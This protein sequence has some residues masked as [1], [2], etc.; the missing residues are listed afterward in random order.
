MEKSLYLLE[1]VDGVNDRPFPSSEGQVEILSFTYN[2]SR[3]GG[4]PT[5]TATVMYGLC[6]DGKWTK[7]VYAEFRGERYF[8]K[9]TPTSHKSNEDAR[10][11]H[12]IELV[13]ERI[14]LDNVYFYDVVSADYA[15]DDKPVSNST[16]VVFFG[17]IYEFVSRL[18]QSMLASRVNYSVVVDEG[19]ESK[20]LDVERLMSFEDMFF[21]DVLQEIYKTY[22]LPYYFDGRT[23]HIG[24]SKSEEIP[25][26]EYGVSGALISIKKSN[27]NNKIINRITGR[28]SSDNIPFYYPNKTPK[29]D[30][31]LELSNPDMRILIADKLLFSEKIS[32]GVP[33][34]YSAN[35]F[36][37][38]LP[39]SGTHTMTNIFKA[40]GVEMPL[41]NTIHGHTYF[42][43]SYFKARHDGDVSLCVTL[44]SVEFNKSTFGGYSN[45]AILFVKEADGRGTIAR[46]DM[47]GGELYEVT[48]VAFK[49][50]EYRVEFLTQADFYVRR[51]ETV[52]AKI[53]FTYYFHSE[54]RWLYEGRTITLE[55]VG[56][57][58]YGKESG[59]TITQVAGNPM[60]T[61]PFL[62]PSI[63]RESLGKERFYNAIN[64]TYEDENGEYYKFSN[65]YVDGNP[66]EYIVDFEEI[67]PTIKDTKN[68]YMGVEYSI[69]KFLDFA[70]DTDDNNDSLEDDSDN[71][72]RKIEHPYFF[73]KLPP[74]G[75]NI[76][77]CAIENSPMTF[78]FTSGQCGA[79]KFKIMVDEKNGKNTVQVDGN[80]NLEYN[81]SNG[82][83]LFGSAQDIQQDT[84]NTSV[85]IALQ[86][87]EDTYGILMPHAPE[88]GGG[89][90]RPVGTNSG[91]GDTFV[92]TGIKLPDFLVHAAEKKLDDELIKY[93]AENNQEKFKFS[94][95]FSRIFLAQNKN[96]LNNL[97]EN[98]R[99][100]V[101]Y[102]N[103]Y[104]QQYVSS[105][106]YK[107]DA[108]EALPSITVELDDTLSVKSNA[109]QNAVAEA[110]T[111]LGKIIESTDVLSKA[112]PYFL[113]KDVNDEAIG[114][115]NFTKGVKFNSG[116][117]VEIVNNNEAKL[118]IDY[119]E[120]KKQA[121][122]NEIEIQTKSYVGGQLLVTLA[123]MECIKV[124]SYVDYYR[125]YFKVQG[126]NFKEIYNQ[127]VVGDQ[128][129]CQEYNTMAT[130]YYWRLVV[131]TGKD[132]VDLS[133]VPGEYDE[134][135]T[136]PQIGDKI[137]HLGNIDTPS[138]QNAI[139]IAAYGEYSPSIIQ[140]KGINSFSITNDNVVTR[141]SPNDNLITG[142]LRIETGSKGLENI[143][144]IQ[145]IGGNNLLRNTSFNGDY[146]SIELDG[147]NELS[148]ESKMFSPNLEH[149]DVD[150]SVNAID[151]SSV[152]AS[153]YGVEFGVSESSIRQEV[154]FEIYPGEDYVV[155][156]KAKS[157]SSKYIRVVFGGKSSGNIDISQS[158]EQYSINIT[159]I[160]GDIFYLFGCDVQLCELQL[161]KSK[162]RT[163]WK[164]STLD[165]DKSYAN[166][167]QTEHLRSA[168]ED[169]STTI[170]GGLV[171]TNTIMVGNYDKSNKE[172]SE[173]TGGVCG[174]HSEDR[175]VAF[176]AGGTMEQA[177]YTAV[178]YYQNPKLQPT[179]EE[180]AN[181]AKFVVTH[182]GRAILNDII[183][184]GTVYATDGEFSGKLLAATGSFSGFIE[185]RPLVINKDNY[186]EYIFAE[187]ENIVR[188]NF[189]QAGTVVV[190]SEEI[191]S[192][193]QINMYDPVDE[194]GLMGI[195]LAGTHITIVNLGG[196]THLWG[197]FFG[198]I[199][200]NG[201]KRH[202]DLYNRFIFDFEAYLP[203]E[204]SSLWDGIPGAIAWKVKQYY[205][206]D[207][208]YE[209]IKSLIGLNN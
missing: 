152:S 138:R 82:N 113:R 11:S 79:C 39:P 75:F 143:D 130:R 38:T 119:L 198:E 140:Y 93:M 147:S 96:V 169:A 181:M 196:T 4:A 151:L 191:S 205:V 128:A 5:I 43:V 165:N 150:G 86:K 179:Q 57:I 24:Y 154:Y 155:S 124:E 46:H 146:T 90:Y 118:T 45:E 61:S 193:T 62:M 172:M 89:A 175:D 63:Y 110:K 117:S 20:L 85:W 134:Y 21:S 98:A 188:I 142:K 1:F 174:Y 133:D 91:K 56:L 67:K 173:V 18:N 40:N 209:K 30:I 22:K 167:L 25:I 194:T 31:G 69:D 13:G 104:Y 48:F 107:I 81:N 135:S 145:E 178:K 160:E 157:Q 153:N 74:M 208:S 120:V 87:E 41:I 176:W 28:G 148:I 55:E 109:I 125:C 136:I 166:S 97:N 66:K 186:K 114:I 139:V 7:K 78:E 53:N 204:Y 19:I 197:R 129:I 199:G 49:G 9:N 34:I 15:E 2:A 37:K 103:K 201:A 202:I 58:G 76:F 16:K 116:G 101:L 64:N 207:E 44:H 92:I 123:S 68:E 132:Y 164:S 180:L 29:G 126:D 187:N 8:L 177:I 35:V 51:N 80:G 156:F 108:G 32:T 95:S 111:E 200:F 183:L 60:N 23:I 99:L 72:N 33:I 27:A 14:V 189:L 84:T 182:G 10:Y 158:W 52:I 171:L 185:R 170:N 47:K 168:I 73:A 122:F 12:N 77:D 102:D 131:G 206:D 159:P 112:L 115:L 36:D 161:E 54:K 127:F 6:L 100:T 26:L 203:T 94:I 121:T 141:L 190:I 144:G 42:D 137:I 3:M 70:Y 50:R 17:N 106:T 195:E 59:D 163:E 184:R 88:N 105:F 192:L 71:N 149:W 65:K 162:I 83:V